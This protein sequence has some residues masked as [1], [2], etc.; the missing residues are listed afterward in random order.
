MRP[1]TALLVFF[2]ATPVGAAEVPPLGDQ[3]AK[4][5]AS[6]VG[7]G[8]VATAEKRDGKWTFAIGG[9]LHQNGLDMRAPR[10]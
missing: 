8:A 2:L 3:A 7:H 4:W 5:A 9:H 6:L 10:R 1:L